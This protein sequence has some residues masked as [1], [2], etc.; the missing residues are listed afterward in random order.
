[1]T[2]RQRDRERQTDRDRQKDK[3]RPRPRWTGRQR[4]LKTESDSRQRQTADRFRLRLRANLQ[5]SPRHHRFDIK[6]EISRGEIRDLWRTFITNSDRT[7]EYH[8]FIRHFGFSM[9]SAAFP[10]AKIQ[11]PRRGDADYMI[12]SRKLNCAAD[13]L[14]DNLRSKVGKDRRK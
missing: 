7:L 10:N 14:Q 12:R 5:H 11:P 9:R 6:P 13:M 4:Q 2:D 1:M 3:D 8:Q